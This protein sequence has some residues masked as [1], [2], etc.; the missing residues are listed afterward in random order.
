MNPIQDIGGLSDYDRSRVLGEF[1]RAHLA[2][3]L[4]DWPAAGVDEHRSFLELGLDSVAAVALHAR[5]T[6]ATGLELPVTLAFDHPNTASLAVYLRG[7]LLGESTEEPSVTPVAAAEGEP[8]AIVGMSTRFPGGVASPEQFWELLAEGRDATSEFPTDR[9]WDLA[10]LYD[11]DP[12]R[13]GTTYTR[14]G[15]FLHDAAEFD[16]AFFGINP[17]EALAMDPQQ[18]LLLESGWHALEDA[19][20][21]PAELRG[22]RTGVYVGA[23]AQDYGPRLEEAEGAEGYLDIGTAGSVAS[24]RI[25]YTL[26]LEGPAVTVDTACSSSLVA[27]HLAVQAL[28]RGECALALA[29]G[30]AVMSSPGGFLS[31]S[32]QRALSAD[33]RCRAFA[34]DADGTGWGEG[35]GTVVLAPLSEARRRG[36]RVLALV[37]GIA[38]NSD[39]AS[40]GL[41][42]P[43]GPAQ[44][45][46]IEQALADA[47]IPAAEVDAVEA[48]GTATLLGDP[49]EANALQAVYGSGRPAE[50]PLLLGSVKSNIGHTQAAAGLAGVIKMVLAMRAG[51]LPAT[52]HVE[53]PTPHVNWADRGVALL[54]EACPWPATDHP[55]R[56]GVSSFGMSGTNAHVILESAPV[57]AASEEPVTFPAP[58]PLP[59][60]A[61]TAAAL[62]AQAAAL[63]EYV[64][65]YPLADLGAALGTTRAALRHRAVVLAED[66]ESARAQL[67]ALAAG[68]DAPGVIRGRGTE[69]GL[70]VL[71]R[72]ELPRGACGALY[73]AYPVFAT[74]LSEACAELNLQLATPLLGALLAEAPELE[75]PEYA[76]AAAFACDVALYRLFESWGGHADLV[77]GTGI[78][79]LAAAHVAG[80]LSLA[81]ACALAGTIARGAGAAELR[82]LTRALSFDRP[83]TSVLDIGTGEPVDAGTLADA[84]HWAGLGARNTVPCPAWSE[85]HQV[86]AVLEL[87]GSPVATVAPTEAA[88]VPEALAAL[89]AQGLELD[90][91]AVYSGRDVRDVCLPGYAFQRERFWLPGIG[92]AGSPR[93]VGQSSAEHPLLGAVLAHAAKDE[94]TLTGRLALAAHPWLGE[95]R[96]RGAAILPGTALL[97]L[98]VQAGGHVGARTVAELTLH[99]P[100]VLP[101][102]AGMTVQATVGEPDAEGNRGFAVHA[103]Q[104]DIGPWTK[105]ASGTLAV[106]PLPPGPEV[107]RPETVGVAADAVYAALAETGLDYGRT[108]RGLHT[109]W[110]SGDEV[111]AELVLP[112]GAPDGF[113]LHPVLSDA[114]LHALELFDGAFGSDGRAWLPFSFGG[115]TVHATGARRARVRMTKTGTDT[116]ALTVAGHDGT[117]IA[118]V[119]SLSLRPVSAVADALYRTGWVPLSRSRPDEPGA[120]WA[121]LGAPVPELDAPAHPDLPALLLSELPEFVLAPVAPR[122]AHAAAG[123]VLDL[124]N[125]WLRVPRTAD[126]RL[127]VLTT[128]ALATDAADTV[129]GLDHAPVTGLV[130]AAQDEETGRILLVDTDDSAASRTVL[131][132]A[133]SAAVAEGETELALREGRAFIPRLS[134]TD[135]HPSTVD[136]PGLDPEGTVLIT[137][138][139]GVLGGSLA[140]HLVCEHGIRHLVLLGRSAREGELDAELA[141]LGAE[142]SVVA[143]DVADKDA[144]A[145]V[146]ADIPENRPLTAVVHA[147]GTLDDG[148][149]GSLTRTRLSTVLTPKVDA[150]LHLHE[151]TKDLPLAA[152]VLFSSSAALLGAAGQ[153][154]Y[155]AANTFLDAL[156]Q[157]R[158]AHGLPALSLQWGLW[159]QASGLTARLGEADHAR[160]R[161]SGLAP[162]PTERALAMFDAA[163]RTG[164]S[165]VAPIILDH[166]AVRAKV[167]TDGGAPLLRGLA[168]AKPRI[169]A[170][171]EDAPVAEQHGSPDQLID[172]VREHVAAV[173]GHAAPHAVEVDQAFT[174][175]GFDSLTAVELRNRLGTALDRRLPATLIFD[176]PNPAALARHLAEESGGGAAVRTPATVVQDAGEPVA[177]VGMGAR[178]PGGVAGPDDLWRLVAEGVDAIGEFPDD[179]GWDLDALYDPDPDVPGKMYVRNGGFLPDALDFDAEFFGISP[180]EAVAMDPQQRQLMEVAWEA[181]EHAGIDPNSLKGSRTG[182]FAGIMYHDHAAR[183]REIPEELEGFLGNGSAASVL[184]GRIAYT[185]GLEGPAMSVD[186]AC[187]SSLVSLHLAAQA[188]RRGE[189]TLAL[190]GGVTVLSTPE[191]FVDFSRQRGLSP[192]GRCRAFAEEADGTGWAEGVGMLVLERL[193]D[194]VSNGHEVLAVVRGSAV[195]SDGASNGLSAPNGPSQQR[196]IEAALVDARLGAGDVDVV[197]AHGTGTALGDPIE[198]QALQAVYGKDREPGRPLWLGSLKSNLGHAQAAAGVGGVIKLVQALRAGLLPR[199]LH[200]SRP[201][202]KIEWDGGGVE[203][204]Q[205]SRAWTSDGPRRGA[206]SSFGISGTNAHVILE[207]APESATEAETATGAGP[208]PV[209]VSG[210]TREALRGQASRLAE[211]V[212]VHPEFSVADIGYS[213]ATGRAE[214]AH[215][216]VV[217]AGDRG[218]LLAGLEGLAAGAESALTGSGS[219]AASRVL[220]V[221]PGQGSQW[222]GMGLEL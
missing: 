178:F 63:V 34:A 148:V 78:G 166:P 159:E 88:T 31:F 174:E 134:T 102:S 109:A 59:V 61:H 199:T 79:E 161:R 167:E 184:T 216:G 181:L 144:L 73:R 168:G 14:R 10:A 21:D 76:D 68:E 152:F 40:N 200:A 83:A 67:R 118:T 1:V 212:R 85:R 186:T 51:T 163:L 71:L 86:R 197:E 114:A 37:S 180:R 141:A 7:R 44:Q 131:A 208:V 57:E 36:L 54:T 195:N 43:S 72:G 132:E 69:G 113:A 101:E 22:S 206:V 52:L 147:A 160:L 111:I 155:A 65:R 133:V 66:P 211:C 24:G 96:V 117:P 222:V 183:L 104:E 122:E 95:H 80:V 218:E 6:E 120:S 205:E 25:A 124:L 153:A 27:L 94:L 41:T 110:R 90:W 177:I 12:D 28:R 20:I 39:G 56:G 204:L 62:R 64:D 99:A 173:L 8:I 203:L 87:G 193:S 92:T 55:R 60:T 185:L 15:G 30:V 29:A 5:L 98:A 189:A 157:H 11:A 23:E 130:R 53:T 47:G 162:L 136:V 77:A 221:F 207:Q 175:L 137:G 140:R 176:Y 196:V 13:P 89:F 32:R 171:A 172:L 129:P 143:C 121:V 123:D 58:W 146:L 45:R 19:G 50:Q 150:A 139:T 198:V 119:E 188:L 215:R 142:V 154:N 100:L 169:A 220:M 145:A 4:E 75:Q 112:D 156:A 105:H 74:A 106:A 209:V 116:V 187:S 35:A 217:V 125:A 213:L 202:A 46:V 170:V 93:E 135:A 149:L 108:F 127:V 2:A 151:L 126:S 158:R 192:D 84:G 49:I 107:P 26:G 48:H 115:V 17:R 9:G 219:V 128:G 103:R 210:K 38:V 42:A 16:A 3:V 138:G 164:N 201:S 194:A 190:A 97:E 214:F 165:V 182:V 70:A 33:G 82:R 81:D 191:V 91:R 179:R 18:R